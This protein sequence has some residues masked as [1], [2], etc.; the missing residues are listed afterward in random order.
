MKATVSK[1]SAEFDVPAPA[2]ELL[3]EISSPASFADIAGHILL[4]KSGSGGTVGNPE[5]SPGVLDVVYAYQ[6]SGKSVSLVL[7]WMERTSSTQHSVSYRGGTYDGSLTWEA[8]IELRPAGS[9]TRLSLTVTASVEALSRGYVGTE[10]V[11]GTQEL[12][13]HIVRDHV[14]PYFGSY[15]RGSGRSASKLGLAAIYTAEGRLDEVML[16]A[17]DYADDLKVGLV[18]IE[19]NGVKGAFAVYD[20]EIKEAWFFSGSE[21]LRGD[22]AVTKIA[23]LDLLVKLSVYTADVETLV[24]GVSSCALKGRGSRRQL[25]TPS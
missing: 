24:N 10:S 13:E 8:S 5:H 1:Y 3:S 18:T 15:T 25:G 2:K 12:I 21:A 14:E 23:E 16:T 6:P 4:L 7:G 22:R 20:G 11:A 17:L 19:A 9:L